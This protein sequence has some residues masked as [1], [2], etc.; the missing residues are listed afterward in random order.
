MVMDIWKHSLLSAYK[1]GGEP[2]EYYH[3]HKFLDSSKLFFHHFKHRIL[4]HNTYG[5]YLC[6]QL[7]GDYIKNIDGKT[8]LVRDIAATHCKEDLNGRVPTLNDWFRNSSLSINID[9]LPKFKNKKLNEFILKPFIMSGNKETLFITCTNFG[10]YLIN[11]FF[12]EK[13]AEA[14]AKQITKNPDVKNFLLDFQITEPWQ[15]TVSQKDLL[16]LKQLENVN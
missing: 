13:E 6:T 5:I 7:F 15:Y 9:I 10:S 4:L 12:G 14:H 3:I 16:L 8:V 1:F 2:E 11:T